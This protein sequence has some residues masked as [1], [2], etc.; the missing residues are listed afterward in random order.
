VGVPQEA[1]VGALPCRLLRTLVGRERPLAL[2]AVGEVHW[3]G[4]KV[5]A[6]FLQKL[7]EGTDEI[8]LFLS[9]LPD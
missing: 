6:S 2:E 4:G 7:G 3:L 8:F 9:L 1:A 5:E